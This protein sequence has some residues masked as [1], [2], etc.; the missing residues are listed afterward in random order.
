MESNLSTSQ[1]EML[2]LNFLKNHVAYKSG[3]LCGNSVH[4]DLRFLAFEM[5]FIADYLH[6]RIID[7]SSIKELTKRWLPNVSEIAPTKSC[8]HRALDD[9]KESLEELKFYRTAIFNKS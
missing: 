3:I 6:Y 8:T 5:P 1:A 9:I 4:M 2:F 7:V